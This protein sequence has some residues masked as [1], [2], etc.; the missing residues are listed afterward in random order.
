MRIDILTIFPGMCDAVLHESILGRAVKKGAVELVA[1]DLRKWTSDRHR[2]VDDAPFGGGPGMVMK[3]E[4][5]SLALRELRRPDSRVIFLSPQGRPLTQSM[6]HELAAL[7]HL[8]LLCGSYE[9]VDERI[10]EHLVDEEISIG[11]YVLTNG[12][13][14]A[15]VLADS[16][17]RLL[18]GVLGD[19]ESARQD[20]FGNGLLDHPHYTRPADFNGWKVPDVLLSGNHAEIARWRASAALDATR[21]KRPDL[22]RAGN[23]SDASGT[24]CS[25]EAE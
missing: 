22:L 8:V 3:I 12:T 19:D 14:P 7:P 13:L 10:I 21:R 1:R 5:V 20:S 4:P 11:D 16:V 17:V 9:G 23:F 15:L 2:S 24:D 6:C 25:R 18:P